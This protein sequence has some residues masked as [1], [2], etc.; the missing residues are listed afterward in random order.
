M[1]RLSFSNLETMNTTIKMIGIALA[2]VFGTG[3]ILVGI[4]QLIE[5][6]EYS[7]TIRIEQVEITIKN[8]IA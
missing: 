3:L 5:K 4:S 8:Q 2:I 7:N 1:L 6:N